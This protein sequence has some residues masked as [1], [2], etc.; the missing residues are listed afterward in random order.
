M[1]KL[2]M[3]GLKH[4]ENGRNIRIFQISYNDQSARFVLPNR[5]RP[6]SMSDAFYFGCSLHS[7]FGMAFQDRIPGSSGFFQK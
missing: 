1:K 6:R 7:I 2:G 5:E 3:P 4:K